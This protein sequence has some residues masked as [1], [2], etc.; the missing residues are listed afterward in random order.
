MF[1]FQ[2]LEN[3]RYPYMA[4]SIQ[5]FWHRW[6]ISLSTW[7]KEYLYIPL[8]GNRKGKMRT[9]LNRY[10]VFAATGIWHGANWTFLCWGLFHGTFLVLESSGLLPIKKCKWKPLRI[11]YTLLL[12]T[13]G[14]VLFRADNITQAWYV[15]KAMFGFG[16][17][18]GIALATAISF[19]SPYYLV[20]GMLAVIGCTDYPAHLFGKCMKAIKKPE[21]AELVKMLLCI[22]GVLLCY[23]ALASDSYNPFIYFR[24]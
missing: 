20:I 21:I 3:F 5:E 14:F 11:L 6:H 12:V 22:V 23:M 16:A 4:D 9:Y 13:V 8:G 18:G 19:L 24:F 1:G 10:I 2:F 15:I 17:S 7:F